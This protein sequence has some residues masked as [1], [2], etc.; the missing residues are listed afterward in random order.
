MT[1]TLNLKNKD[2]SPWLVIVGLFII[3]I[4]LIPGPFTLMTILI[5]ILG[6]YF[7]VSGLLNKRHED[8]LA[9]LMG[10]SI[11]TCT[12]IW[13]SIEGTDITNYS[14]MTYIVIALITIILG[15]LGWMGLVPEWFRSL[16]R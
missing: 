7:T 14:K 5:I 12:L 6:I 10:I 2:F 1:I 4:A 16:G 15:I 11:L 8:T 3:S 13:T 9:I